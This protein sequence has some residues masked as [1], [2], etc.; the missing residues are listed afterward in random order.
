[1]SKFFLEA[2]IEELNKYYQIGN[3]NL[4]N[5]LV[6]PTSAGAGGGGGGLPIPGVGG[7]GATVDETEGNQNLIAHAIMSRVLN[8]SEGA[9][10]TKDLLEGPVSDALRNLGGETDGSITTDFIKI[11]YEGGSGDPITTK[12]YQTGDMAGALRT[13]SDTPIS[14]KSVIAPVVKPGDTAVRAVHVNTDPKNPDRFKSPT[15]SAIVFPNLKTTI[16]SRHTDSVSLFSGAIPTVE[17][18]RCMPYIDITLVTSRIDNPDDPDDQT[19]QTFGMMR[20]LGTPSPEYGDKIMLSRAQTN[21]VLTQYTGPLAS[22]AAKEDPSLNPVIS[23]TGM[24]IFTSPQT[25]VNADINKEGY[26]GSSGDVLDPFKPLMTL[27]GINVSI[28]GLGAGLYSSKR[29]T[30]SL[31]LHDRSR[32]RDI[33]PLIAVDQIALT[34]VILEYGWSHPDGDMGSSNAY[35]K[36][37]NNLRTRETFNI[38]SSN[39][40]MGNDGQVR[41]EVRMAARGGDDVRKVPM[42]TGDYVPT[43]QFKDQIEAFAAQ[44]VKQASKSS[45]SKDI[46]KKMKLNLRSKTSP[47]NII[48]RATYDKFLQIAGKSPTSAGAP[49]QTTS[50]S[51]QGL[52]D[53]LGELLQGDPDINSTNLLKEA[54]CKLEGL[55]QGT[56][57]FLDIDDV[58]DPTKLQGIVN[59]DGT[60]NYSSLGKIVMSFIGYPMA[61]SGFYDEVQVMFYPFNN[62]AAGMRGRN[63]C[64]FPIKHDVFAPEMAKVLEKSPVPSVGSVMKLLNSKFLSNP[65][66]L[67]YGLSD[68]YAD[69]DKAKEGADANGQEIQ[70]MLND[71]LTRRLAE[72]YESDQVG[73]MGAE[74]KFVK[75]DVR[76]Y[77]ESTPGIIVSSIPDNNLNPTGIPK[78]ALDPGRTVLRIH[79]FDKNATPHT[80]EMTLLE[81]LSSNAV[82]SIFSGAGGA[83]PEAVKTSLKDV[84]PSGADY[85]LV[86]QA[87]N[88]GLI[89]VEATTPIETASGASTPQFKLL[90]PSGK[91]AEREIK[92][93]I[94]GSSPALFYGTEFSTLSSV[95]L[96]ARTS[97][98]VQNALLVTALEKKGD[99]SSSGAGP[100]LEDITVIPASIRVTMLGMPLVEYGQQFFLDLK[101]GTTADNMYVVTNLE[102]TI[103][104]GEFE[105][106]FDLT[107]VN[108]GSMTS[109]HT[110]LAQVES[111]LNT[112]LTRTEG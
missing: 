18:S 102:H 58:T 26:G 21:E 74:P 87:I 59:P 20:F 56:D 108:Q 25:L 40:N 77:M 37:L 62:Q 55:K 46:T 39:F 4:E 73:S 42:I 7:G 88:E 103:G 6:N 81:S 3:R 100:N 91:N 68:L 111:A 11:F 1:M 98:T 99:G 15:L 45:D 33:A 9:F 69:A 110:K 19:E 86:I 85:S 49:P 60:S 32:M 36:F 105:T 94:A 27:E 17:I 84:A 109:L 66:A 53:L 5:T 54:N 90:L 106:T 31:T 10:L 97:G 67:A 28:E 8:V 101:T 24:E 34:S 61:A 41:I 52:I 48:Q 44:K 70:A 63:I 30:M 29:A 83:T 16:A 2:A 76:F 79:I 112:A 22:A 14:I 50:E 78:M 75:P 38:V 93:L 23:Q 65:T 35:G 51:T 43:S 89:E 71:S 80:A 92:R 13:E 96:T 104:P 72:L 107:F 64:Q 12:Y 47:A 82:A 95:Y 57:P